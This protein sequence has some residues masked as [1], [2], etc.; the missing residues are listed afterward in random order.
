MCALYMY[1]LAP[2]PIFYSL[3]VVICFFNAHLFL[4]ALH[5]CNR[6]VSG[7]PK[8]RYAFMYKSMIF[9]FK[10]LVHGTT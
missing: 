2:E 8:V 4:D 7:L 10:V 5:I 9:L 1:I 3:I 6:P